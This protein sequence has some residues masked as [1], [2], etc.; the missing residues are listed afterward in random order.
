[1]LHLADQF[2]G[3][4]RCLHMHLVEPLAEPRQSADAGPYSCWSSSPVCCPRRRCGCGS[5]STGLRRQTGPPATRPHAG[6][7]SVATRA[8]V[9]RTCEPGLRTRGGA[10]P[11]TKPSAPR[12]T[13][14]QTQGA[15]R[16]S[17]ER[18]P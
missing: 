2:L 13:R 17:P 10:R 3:T 7:P 12:A 15:R 18:A 14:S 6:R 5:G 11:G 9:T 16:L 4:H 8:P 1:V